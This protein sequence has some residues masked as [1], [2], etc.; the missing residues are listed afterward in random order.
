MT[1]IGKKD[2]SLVRYF[3]DNARYADLLNGY[4]FRGK[5][6]VATEDVQEMDSHVTGIDVVPKENKI[7][8]T[9]QFRDLVRKTI[10]GVGCVIVEI[11]N[12]D[13]I[14][15]AMPIRV[16]SEEAK[17]YERQMKQ[18]QKRHEEQKDLRKSEEFLGKFA[19]NDH[20]N[21]IVSLV[22]YYGKEPWDGPKDL[23]EMLD[24]EEIP[25]E[26]KQLVNHY[27]LHVLEVCRFENTEWFQTDLREV[28]EVI[29]HADNKKSLKKFVESNEKRLD[30]MARDACELI[31][32]VTNTPEFAFREDRYET[33]EG[34]VK[35]CQGMKE[36][37]E[38]KYETGHAEGHAEER[39]RSVESIM[40]N[41]K[42]SLEDACRGIGISIEE[43][44][45][46]KEMAAS[47]ATEF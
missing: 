5:Q 4:V 38:E 14:H 40:Q 3:D 32:A 16:L 26:M 27:P 45:T 10:F 13:K 43:Y 19:K 34:N 46:A 25:E 17:A 22:I 35:M 42:L 28:F 18:I 20:V 47:A 9:Q 41:L 24:L 30:N 21:G 36:R 6:V 39:V 33:E 11:E 29:R 12:Q 7:T 44:Y 2:I 1:K 31:A 23:Y 37:L 8:Y 15:Y